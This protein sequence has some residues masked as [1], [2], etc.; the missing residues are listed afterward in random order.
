[1]QQFANY[2]YAKHELRGTENVIDQ[3]KHLL[4]RDMERQLIVLTSFAQN[5]WI[6]YVSK[7]LIRWYFMN[8]CRLY[9]VNNEL[10][11]KH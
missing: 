7:L 8:E 1:M 4:K 2:Y 9:N 3:V 6:H 10:C 11:Q 5:M